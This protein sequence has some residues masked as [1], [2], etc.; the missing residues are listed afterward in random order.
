MRQIRL[1][2]FKL[3]KIHKKI[4]RREKQIVF[5]QNYDL[6]YPHRESHKIKQKGFIHRLMH[7]I[8]QKNSH[9]GNERMF[10]KQNICFVKF[11]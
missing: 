4:H 6:N 5:Y 3:Y 11:V 9:F 1:D 2:I 7:I 10:V 8:H